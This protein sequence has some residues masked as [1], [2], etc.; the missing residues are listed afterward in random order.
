MRLCHLGVAETRH[1]VT[2]RDEAAV[3]WEPVAAGLVEILGPHA[4]HDLRVRC[5][6]GRAPCLLHGC[7]RPSPSVAFSSRTTRLTPRSASWT[8]R[9]RPDGS[10]THDDD[11][12]TGHTVERWHRLNG[13]VKSEEGGFTMYG[14][15][16][17]DLRIQRHGAGLRGVVDAA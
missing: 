15:T 8:R 12:S 4:K 17:E 11:V 7:S 3:E 16:E 10:A 2:L 9:P 14:L 13:S 5:R 6:P 1:Q